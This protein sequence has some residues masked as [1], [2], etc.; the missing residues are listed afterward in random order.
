MTQGRIATA[1][2]VTDPV[3]SHLERGVRWPMR[4]EAIISSYEKECGLSEGELWRRAA[5]KL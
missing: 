3:I 4:I 1:A 2:G 5:G